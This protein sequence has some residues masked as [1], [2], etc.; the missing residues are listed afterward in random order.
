MALGRRAVRVA[1]FSVGLIATL[2]LVATM[3]HAQETEAPPELLV[4]SSDL[5][6]SAEA[7]AQAAEVLPP[8]AQPERP[9][10]SMGDLLVYSGVDVW[11]YGGSA[12]VG[13]DWSLPL[14]G[15][16]EPVIRLFGANGIDDFKTRFASYRT[17][18]AR[19]SIMPG[20]RLREGSL[21]I[22]L[23]VGGDYEMRA[24]LDRS[25]N[26]PKHFFGV[27]FAGD[28]WWEPDA[29]WMLSGSAS[30]TSIEAGRS[31]RL[32]AGWRLPFAWIGPEFQAMHDVF[33]TQYRAGAH[34]T[35]FKIGTTEWS[36]AGGYAR[37]SFHRS[38]PYARIG[39]AFRL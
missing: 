33:N 31:A 36:L 35:G 27:R 20:I 32:A 5:G 21:E 4:D 17:D 22:K 10:S 24:A 34:L 29:Q 1:W 30:A 28:V 6:S 2:V 12:Y 38:G 9:N 19:G 23:F 7:H 3:A 26:N 18:T 37:D 11:R 15:P 14:K 13:S 25:F 8:V 16:I 39:V